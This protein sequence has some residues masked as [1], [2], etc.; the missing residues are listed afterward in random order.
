M[1]VPSNPKDLKKIQAQI[2]EISEATTMIEDRRSYINDVKKELREE[3]EIDN[4]TLTI[5]IKA[6][7]TQ[8]LS[9]LQ[10]QVEDAEAIINA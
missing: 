1:A 5:M 10:E 2:K 3:F 7:H 4:K 8:C 9:E 6:F